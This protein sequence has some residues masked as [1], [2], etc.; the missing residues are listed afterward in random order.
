[1]TVEHAKKREMRMARVEDAVI[2]ELAVS[3]LDLL[4][5]MITSISPY[6]MYALTLKSCRLLYRFSSNDSPSH[7]A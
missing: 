6:S 7:H 3:G 4:N 1:M 5:M 2:T